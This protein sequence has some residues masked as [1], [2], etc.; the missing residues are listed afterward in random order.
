MDPLFVLH[1]RLVFLMHII[2]LNL[3]KTSLSLKYDFCKDAWKRWIFETK[4]LIYYTVLIANTIKMTN[5]ASNWLT[6]TFMTSTS[7]QIK[8]YWTINRDY[9]LP[10]WFY[11]TICKWNIYL[12][13]IQFTLA[14]HTN[15]LVL[16]SSGFPRLWWHTC[17]L[18]RNELFSFIACIACLTGRK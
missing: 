8:G 12:T 17:S 6:Y 4:V 14:I 7:K 2:F 3:S 9:I 16:V 1:F 18:L 5:T 10:W 13:P 11:R 15:R